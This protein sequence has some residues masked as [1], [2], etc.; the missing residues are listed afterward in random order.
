MDYF[1]TTENITIEEAQARIND[2]NKDIT[3]ENLTKIVREEN[4][5]F[6][7]VSGAS[8]AEIIATTD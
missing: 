2:A 7:N 8:I 3:D 4:G 1:S 5:K 6:Y